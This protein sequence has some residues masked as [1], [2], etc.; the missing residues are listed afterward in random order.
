MGNTCIKYNCGKTRPLRFLFDRSKQ[1]RVGVGE[2]DKREF[3]DTN[4][5]FGKT[6]LSAEHIQ[7]EEME[8]TGVTKPNYKKKDHLD[9]FLAEEE[10]GRNMRSE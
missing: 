5:H 8:N 9:F 1:Y 6:L 4:L 10:S 7:Q 3:E 2:V